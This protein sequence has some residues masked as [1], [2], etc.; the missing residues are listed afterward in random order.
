MPMILRK[1][2][3][4]NLTILALILGCPLRLVAQEP[5]KDAKPAEA[6]PGDRKNAENPVPKEESSVTD[7]AIRIGGQTIVYKATASTTLL[8]NEKGDPTAIIFT[9]A[10]TKSDVKDLSQR[11]I[12]FLYN[13]GPGSA[14]AWL[15]MGA[16]GPR[17]VMTPNA[18]FA[19]PPPYRV[20]DNEQS[21]LDKS[22]LVFIDP[23]GTGYS[24]AVGK[25]QDKEFW[26]IDSD[27]KSFAQVINT[28]VTRNNRWN[29]PK[30]LIGES[31]GTFRSAALSNY[32]QSNDGMYLNGIVLL[33]T[34]L[35][36]GTL[37]F[38]P[39]NDMP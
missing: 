22:D 23:V 25:S 24:R 8:K 32:L 21:L 35:D 12:A 26:G 28:Y 19:P 37:S 31:Y 6:A 15:H 9:V 1:P 11:P 14:S 33:S 10:Y 17:R 38:S 29:S 4:W 34:V 27:V 7:H 30:F 2:K 18:E 5:S 13:G 16:F 39:G 20:G 36:F 3:I